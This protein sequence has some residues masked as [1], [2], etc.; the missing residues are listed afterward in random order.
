MPMILL[1]PFAS[2]RWI[3]KG[4]RRFSARRENG[5]MNVSHSIG[6][7]TCTQKV[8]T[9]FL[10]NLI[11]AAPR[12]HSLNTASLA[13]CDL[14]GELCF[15]VRSKTGYALSSKGAVFRR[16]VHPLCSEFLSRRLIDRSDGHRRNVLALF[17]EAVRSDLTDPDTRRAHQDRA[18]AELLVHAA[19]HVP[20]YRSLLADCPISPE[21]ARSILSTLPIVSR[22][23]LQ[24]NPDQFFASSVHPYVEDATGGSSGTPLRFRVDRA[25]QRAREASLYWADSLA[26]WRYGERIAMLWGCDRDVKTAFQSARA[27]VR[28]WIEN[29]RWYNAFDMG[30][31][32]MAR[33]HHDMRRFRPHIIVAY[34]GSMDLYA[35]FLEAR[36]IRPDY[37]I[38]SIIC[39]AEVLTPK[40]RE[41]IERVFG[42]PVF[43]RYGSREFGAIAAE[44]DAHQGLHVNERDMIVEVDSPD[45]EK[46]PGRVVVT[47]LHNR[48]MPFI[49][50]DTGD[51]A[52]WMP[53]TP[54][55]CGRSSARL[56][57]VAGRASDMIRTAAGKLIHG[58]FFTHLLYNVQ[59]VKEFQFV[60][61]SLQRYRLRLVASRQLS[62][63]ETAWLRSRIVEAV[64][65]GSR[66][67]IE[68]VDQIPL[69]PSGKRRF[70]ISQVS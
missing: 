43:N 48:A 56:E 13:R 41:T 47:Y 67:E 54:C 32:R 1:G 49:R 44:C 8:F 66:I 17:A 20:F 28:W 64:G 6:W 40:A 55:A 31:D 14:R 57:S 61:E 52:R 15:H 39:S 35:R 33:F 10:P 70:T 42:K 34:A 59:G 58:E 27:H 11:V 69:L 51:L 25:T 46:M 50:Y 29:R 2:L 45:P 60:Q 65:E 9:V 38:R 68:F 24:K 62:S 63:S 16:S 5:F 30:E 3:A 22:D 53:P 37:P 4:W 7:R 18:L 26:G 12:F 21:N 23:D 19:T 36:G